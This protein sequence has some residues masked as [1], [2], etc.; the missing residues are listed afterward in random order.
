MCMTIL[1]LE[2]FTSFYVLL[3]WSS[4]VFVLLLLL[5]LWMSER[6]CSMLFMPT[7]AYLLTSTLLCRCVVWFYLPFPPAIHFQFFFYS[8]CL[9][10]N[11]VLVYIFLLDCRYPC[12]CCTVIGVVVASFFTS[13]H[14]VHFSS[15]WI[16]DTRS[17]FNSMLLH[18]KRVLNGWHVHVFKFAQ[19]SSEG[20]RTYS[21]EMRWKL[22]NI[23]CIL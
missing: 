4:F 23:L 10:S 6:V 15:D 17:S 1:C 21:I 20:W 9:P 19:D 16:H 13:A 8:N 5:L 3:L 7:L 2:A 11:L 22:H 12:Y 14:L 18:V